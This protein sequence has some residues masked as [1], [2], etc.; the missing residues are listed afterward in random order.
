MNDC[1]N[2]QVGATPQYNNDNIKLQLLSL[3][4]TVPLDN[5]RLTQNY[6]TIQQAISQMNNSL[7]NRL[8]DQSKMVLDDQTDKQTVYLNQQ[9]KERSKH[10]QSQSAYKKNTKM[11]NMS[12]KL[13]I[14]KDEAHEQKSETSLKPG[15]KQGRTSKHRTGDREP[16]KIL[17]PEFKKQAGRHDSLKVSNQYEII[18]KSY[19]KMSKNNSLEKK[20][21]KSINK[22]KKN[23][24]G[25]HQFDCEVVY[26]LSSSQSEEDHIGK[27]DFKSKKQLTDLQSGFQRQTTDADRRQ[28]DKSLL[29]LHRKHHVKH[30]GQHNK[31]PNKDLSLSSPIDSQMKIKIEKQLQLKKMSNQSGVS[32]FNM[33]ARFQNSSYDEANMSIVRTLAPGIGRNLNQLQNIQAEVQIK[34]NKLPQEPPDIEIGSTDIC[35]EKLKPMT[36]FSSPA[37]QSQRTTRKGKKTYVHS[38]LAHYQ[39]Y[40]QMRNMQDV[41]RVF[42]EA[43]NSKESELLSKSKTN[44][45]VATQNN[46][47]MASP[48]KEERLMSMINDSD[49]NQSITFS[50]R[51]MNNKVSIHIKTRRFGRA[52]AETQ[53]VQK[54]DSAQKTFFSQVSAKM[55]EAFTNNKGRFNSLNNS[56]DSEKTQVRNS[57]TVR[58]SFTADINKQLRGEARVMSHRSREFMSGS[59]NLMKANQKRCSTRGESRGYHLKA[60]L[61]TMNFNN[62]YMAQARHYNQN[63]L[64]Q[65]SFSVASRMIMKEKFKQN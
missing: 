27:E 14:S 17:H 19:H 46:S 30:L 1:L 43:P 64:Y 56:I 52:Q 38:D 55:K 53:L 20:H 21:S 48:K 49:T 4:E 7:N 61:N 22:D 6:L 44:T 33:G 31:K 9:L 45:K 54:D 42:Q 60:S 26:G 3:P 24:Y 18:E 37:I 65:Q 51:K 16:I 13:L 40:M 11:E 23:M 58:N 34:Q 59:M 32:G 5:S 12:M 2:Q 57:G 50:Q 62:T 39:L 29:E 15:D 35:N 25:D 47:K 63:S 41:G 28:T 36:K 10:M 8:K